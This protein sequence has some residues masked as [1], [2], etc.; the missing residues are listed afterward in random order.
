M[1]PADRTLAL[2]ICLAGAAAA[3]Q[4]AGTERL[5]IVDA[6]AGCAEFWRRAP[7]ATK[8]EQARAFEE[9]LR[10]PHPSLYTPAVLG[11]TEPLSASVPERLAK[12][13]ARFRPDPA[14]VEEVRR[15]LE[16]DLHATATEFRK[17]FPGFASNRPV[18]LVCS[19]GA[20]DGGTRSVE[21]KSMLLFGPDV[22]AAIRPRGFDLRPF[23]EHELF[24]V[25]HGNL[26]PDAPET[27]GQSLW[28]EGLA[29]Y[30]S[31]QLNPGAT[32]DEVSVPEALVA[33]ATPRI[34]EL[35]GRL[36]AHLDDPA[37]GPVYRQFF[38]GSTEKAEV[39]PRSGYVLG[40]RIA[41]AAGKTRS[42]AQLAALSPA[43]SRAVV[44]K[45]LKGMARPA[46]KTK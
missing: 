36:L 13:P 45:A 24:H 4:D 1:L 9:L 21:G 27:V 22:I 14:R 5:R 34:P 23:L 17:T 39:P 11:L 43:E 30:V 7:G 2:L 10:A 41:E 35:A 25:H 28:E 19:L 26:H 16:A 8:E 15:T 44:E 33:E 20:F 46:A 38:Y 31:A 37:D 32:A 3:A 12:L 6:A 40:W 18:A 29:T 42:L